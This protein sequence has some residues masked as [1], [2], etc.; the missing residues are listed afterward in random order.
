MKRKQKTPKEIKWAL[1]KVA[2]TDFNKLYVFELFF[3]FS[4]Y[5]E[6]PL[7]IECLE[8]KASE[9]W[10]N[11]DMCAVIHRC[12]CLSPAFLSIRFRLSGRSSLPSWAPQRRIPIWVMQVK[13]GIS[14]GGDFSQHLR[15]RC[16]VLILP[17]AGC[18]RCLL[19]VIIGAC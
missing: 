11:A 16:T 5:D 18:W 15:K 3:L 4:G 19:L 13:L 8:F 14:H 1:C 10:G 6:H 9:S 12:H 7:F 2:I 17:F